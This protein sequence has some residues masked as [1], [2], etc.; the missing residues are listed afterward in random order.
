MVIPPILTTKANYRSIEQHVSE[1]LQDLDDK[2]IRFYVLECS[3]GTV[4]TRSLKDANHNNQTA[5]A[6]ADVLRRAE[7]E[8]IKPFTSLDEIAGDPEITTDFD[9]DVFLKQVREDRDRQSIRRLIN[10]DPGH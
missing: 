3:P 10:G 2:V 5:E 7:A 6:R 9:V 8:G 4:M 1:I